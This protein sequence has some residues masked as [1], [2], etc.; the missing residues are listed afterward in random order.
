M[1]WVSLFDL[2]GR[3]KLFIPFKALGGVKKLEGEVIK[4]V[5]LEAIPGRIQVME[6]KYY[7]TLEFY[8]QVPLKAKDEINIFKN[9]GV[10]LLRTGADPR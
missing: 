3:K 10:F 4:A 2:E 7:K 1:L 9:G 6:T 5:V 8:L